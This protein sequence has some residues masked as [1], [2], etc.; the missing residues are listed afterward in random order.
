MF[1]DLWGAGVL[2]PPLPPFLLCCSARQ[3]AVLVVGDPLS[4]TTHSDLIVRCS[5]AGV[6]WK[7]IH[8][9]SIMTAVGQCGLQLYRCAAT[10]QWSPP[11]QTSPRF[12]SVVW[13]IA[14]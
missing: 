7:V 2:C 13:F 3:V 10:I 8:N 12:L 14:S 11:Q 6:P 5:E 9:A 1:G 4:A